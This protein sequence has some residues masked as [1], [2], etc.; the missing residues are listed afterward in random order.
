MNETEADPYDDIW[1]DRTQE[2]SIMDA[3]LMI[4]SDDTD[5]DSIDDVVLGE[6]TFTEETLESWRNSD[7]L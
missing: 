1:F 7:R 6:T 4:E 2:N 5:Y 3:W